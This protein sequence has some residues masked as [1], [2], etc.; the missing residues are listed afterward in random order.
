M[1]GVCRLC[2]QFHVL[3]RY[4]NANEME[5]WSECMDRRT[6]LKDGDFTGNC[7]IIRG[8]LMTILKQKCYKILVRCKRNTTVVRKKGRLSGLPLCFIACSELVVEGDVRTISPL[9]AFVHGKLYG[10]E[11]PMISIGWGV[12]YHKLP[13]WKILADIAD[14]YTCDRETI[15]THVTLYCVKVWT[16]PQMLLSP[17]S[18]LYSDN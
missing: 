7:E 16:K 12:R 6:W 11:C 13:R 2:D 15:I 10:R 18:Y 3:V 14:M 9:H 1:M 4:G 17:T 8:S 5:V